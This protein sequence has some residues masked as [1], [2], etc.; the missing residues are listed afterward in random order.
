MQWLEVLGFVGGS[1][2]GC[3]CVPMAWKAWRTG[4]HGTTPTSAMWLFLSACIT[5]FGYLFLRFG[6]HF[7]F[8]IGIVETLCWL[9]VIR[10]RYWPRWDGVHCTL[11]RYQEPPCNGLPR[12]TCPQ[13]CRHGHLDWDKCPVCCH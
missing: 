9:I 13:L 8:V 6:F 7:A 2:F 1:L 4:T 11:A 10:Y 3:A 12:I 5:Y